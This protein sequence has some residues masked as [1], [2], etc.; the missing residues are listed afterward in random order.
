V[1]EDFT[2]ST[3]TELV[4][5][6][7]RLLLD[8]GSALDLE[9]VSVTPAPAHPGEARARA[10]FSIV[11]CGPPDPVVPQRIYRL[12]NESLGP[13]E[14]FVV[15]IGPDDSGMQYEAVFG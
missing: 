11:F 8:D 5:E 13:V 12:E 10:P 3:F 14:L 2:P 15:P 6:P 7:F 9:L 1:I 4:G